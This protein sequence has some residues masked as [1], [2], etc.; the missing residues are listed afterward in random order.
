MDEVSALNHPMGDLDHLVLGMLHPHCP[1]AAR[2]VLES[3]GVRV[4][5]LRQALVDSLGDPFDKPRARSR[6]RPLRLCWS[7]PTWR[8]P[9]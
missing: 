7:G 2:A 3:F 8:R 4:E 6:P 1:G 9:G 5:T